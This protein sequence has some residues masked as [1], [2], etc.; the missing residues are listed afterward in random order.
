M[1][2]FELDKFYA[3]V[4]RVAKPD[5]LLASWGYSLC[6]VNPS[7]DEFVNDFYWN[8]VGPYWDSARKIV[9]EQYSN[10]AFPFKK[11]EAPAFSIEVEW[12]QDE[13]A[14]YLT[15]WSAT[16]KYIKSNG[17]DPV[18]S[19]IEKIAPLWGNKMKVEFP[20]FLKLGKVK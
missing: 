19:V 15:T 7:I 13:F 6:S 1:H 8:T 3:E 11:I 16:Q 4:K 14:G 18:P 2:W 20:V 5:A 10:L 12:T 9:E 17:V